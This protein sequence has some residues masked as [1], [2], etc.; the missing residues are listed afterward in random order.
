MARPNKFKAKPQTIDGT[1]YASTKEAKRSQELGILQKAGLIR[2]L[3]IHPSWPLVVNGHMIGRYTSDFSYYD[4]EQSRQV[5]EDV[6]SPATAKLA[7]YRL[8]KKLM[9]ALY[10]IQ[11]EE[12]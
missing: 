5:V 12:V 11:I 4:V 10:G 2:N 3:L 1:R 7:D 6:K 9:L 8:R